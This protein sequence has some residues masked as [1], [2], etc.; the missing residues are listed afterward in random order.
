MNP[1]LKQRLSLLLKLTFVVI[2]LYFMAKKG[3]LSAEET[4]KALRQWNLILPAFGFLILTL[5]LASW[6][7][8]LLLGAAGLNLGYRRTLEFNLVGLFFNIAL[9]GS[10]TGDVVK[11][12]YCSREAQGSRAP[13]L[14]TIIFD[15]VC[16]VSGLILIGVGALLV[17][18]SGFATGAKLPVA[19]RAPILGLGAGVITFFVYLFLVRENWDPALQL[20]Q[21]LQKRHP[22]VGSLTRLY[23]GIKSYGKF[24]ATTLSALALS[25]MIQLLVAW[26]CI[27][28][29]WAMGDTDIPTLSLAVVIPLGL[30]V[31]VIPVLPGGMGTGHAAFLAL[32]HLLG[33][34]RGAD[35]F[36]LFLL[37][38]LLQGAVGGLFY[39]RFRSKAPVIGTPLA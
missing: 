28:F 16:G 39:L 31:M 21:N 35:V 15:R 33:S 26:A 3:F 18:M 38:S 10:V 25:I 8:H 5:L 11:A 36:N 22:K 29:T 6:R 2:L 24:K 14:S 13:V 20:L 9:P 7:W 1:K 30:L 23:E 12:Y 19:V 34:N 37:N 17:Q 32:F 27:Q 4:L